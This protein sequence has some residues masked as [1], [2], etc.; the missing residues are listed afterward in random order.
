VEEKVYASAIVL[1]EAE[2]E[3]FRT[4]LDISALIGQVQ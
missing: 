3:I 4:V 1:A 2:S